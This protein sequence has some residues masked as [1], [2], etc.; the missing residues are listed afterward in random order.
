[1]NMSPLNLDASSVV[2][3]RR[4]GRCGR[5]R[6]SAEALESQLGVMKENVA[7]KDQEIRRLKTLARQ[8][9]GSR[10]GRRCTSRLTSLRMETP[11][12]RPELD[13]RPTSSTGGV[14]IGLF[15]WAWRRVPWILAMAPTRVLR[16]VE[17]FQSGLQLY[18]RPVELSSSVNGIQLK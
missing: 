14:S 16:L 13:V 2:G 8:L 1:M 15:M 9:E 5:V 7:D 3:T 18:S 11:M 4:L 17:S 6:T 10:W 12:P